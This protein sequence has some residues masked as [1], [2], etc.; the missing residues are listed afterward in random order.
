[1]ILQVGGEG[2]NSPPGFNCTRFH[3]LQ[4]FTNGFFEKALKDQKTDNYCLEPQTTIYKWMFQLDDSKSLKNGCFTKHPF[5]KLL[6]GDP[7][8]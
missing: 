5:K 8:G 4:I 1:M 6:F 3:Q 2:N 7:G